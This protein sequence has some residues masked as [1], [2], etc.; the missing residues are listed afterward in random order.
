MTVINDTKW[1]F[2]T[3]PEID[4]IAAIRI[5]FLDVD[6]PEIRN[7][8]FIMIPLGGRCEYS[9]DNRMFYIYDEHDNV[10]RN[11]HAPENSAIDISYI[12]KDYLDILDGIN[13]R[14]YSENLN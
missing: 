12:T 4:K 2:E 6:N 13:P 10:F 11:V 8:M 9:P 5:R 14:A 7:E 3:I 1:D